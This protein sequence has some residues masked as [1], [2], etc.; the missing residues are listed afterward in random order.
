ERKVRYGEDQEEQLFNVA[1][2]LVITWINRMLFLKL[3]EAQLFRYHRQDRKFRFLNPKVIDGFD[4]LNKLFFQVLARR[5]ED[6]SSDVNEKFGHIP[7]LNSSL[8]DAFTLEKYTF[9]ISGLDDHFEIPVYNRS[10]LTKERGNSLNTLEYLFRFLDAYDFSTEGYEEIRDESKTLINASVLGLIF[11]K[12]NG[13]KDG[14]FYTPGFITE[15]MARETL[16]KAVIDTCN[17]EYGWDCSDFT[18]LYNHIHREKLSLKEANHLINDL[19]ICDPAVGSGHFLV[20][21]LNELLAIKSEL[22]IL[23][24]SDGKLLHGASITVENDEL[25]IAWKDDELFEYDVDHTW[26]GHRIK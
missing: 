6:R 7:Y 22:G 5:E 24:D 26:L 20:S 14:S 11:E 18:E 9:H 12:I 17:R 10:V 25:I 23:C 2:E 1:M 13:Y 19:K 15:Y 3:L 4:E 8:F 16:R 21:C